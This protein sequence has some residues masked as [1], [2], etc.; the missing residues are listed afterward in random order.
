MTES[1]LYMFQWCQGTEAYNCILRLMGARIAWGSVFF[2]LVDVPELLTIERHC[3]VGKSVHIK[4]C[5]LGIR[6]GK[7]T[8]A[9]GAVHIR[10]NSSVGDQCALFGGSIIE[11][12]SELEVSLLLPLAVRPMPM[13]RPCGMRAIAVPRAWRWHR[14][15][16]SSCADQAP[17][18]SLVSV[19]GTEL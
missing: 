18:R 1:I 5:S 19:S 15:I 7:P 10:R 4:C 3:V 12:Y 6:E 17:S 8:L 2:G 9:L 13:P 16:I 14:D 11:P